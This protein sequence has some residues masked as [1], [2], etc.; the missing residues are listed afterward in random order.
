[1]IVFAGATQILLGKKPS[2]ARTTCRHAGLVAIGLL[3]GVVCWSGLGGGAFMT[4]PFM[5]FCG[6][7]M[8]TAIGTGAALGV[9][10]ASSARSASCSPAGRSPICPRSRSASSLT[11]PA[12]WAS[13]P[14]AS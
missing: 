2:A 9:P 10:V 3:I 7:T 4:V 12:C 8:T 14:A 6:V 11:G 1:M 13:S 5:L